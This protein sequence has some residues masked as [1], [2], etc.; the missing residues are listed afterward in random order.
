MISEAI[1][2]TEER[3]PLHTAPEVNDR[4]KIDTEA[5]IEYYA[6][7]KDQ[8]DKRLQELEREWDTER[9]LEANASTLV[10]LSVLLGFTSSRKWFILPG[11][12]G[13][14]LLQHAIQ[15][16]CPPLPIIRRL[17]FRTADEINREKMA[18]RCLKGDICDSPEPII[19]EKRRQ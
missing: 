14:F 6:K 19:N 4:I 18:L 11:I 13:T 2:A 8:I 9:F 12:V 5:K 15:G 1:P 16:W 17:G 7:H 10:V 3:V